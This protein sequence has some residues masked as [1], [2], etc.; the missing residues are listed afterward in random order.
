VRGVVF[1]GDKELELQT[2]ED[3]T[4]GPGE[5][6]LEMKAS[7]M[8]GTDLKFYR[9]PKPFQVRGAQF[10]AGHEPCGV[11]VA[12]GAG[13]T[14]QMAKAGDRVMVH[15][16]LGCTMCNH[17]RTGWSQ[18][19]AEVPV[20]AYGYSGHGGHAP[21]MVAP[22]QTLVKLP[23][24]LSYET[25]AAISCGT[26]TAFQA[27]TRMGVSGRDTIAIFGQGPVGASATQLA[28]AMGAEVIAVDINPKRANKAAEFGATHIVDASATDP[29]E[30]IR[31]LTRG[32]GVSKSLD[33]SGHS[34]ARAQ[35][36]Q[37]CSPWAT[38]AF[39]GEG[40][41]VTLDVSAWVL[42][43]Q[44]TVF[45]SWTFS[46]KGQRDCAEFIAARRVN[47][48]KIFTDRYALDQAAAAYAAFDKGEGG[49]GVFIF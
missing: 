32:R 1:T 22:V 21:Y 38:V 2:F 11:V 36:V 33:A 5:V 9:S 46:T 26:G 17:C 29:I 40:G 24:E 34:T 43:K 28:A 13:V 49:K 44:L 39:V 31:A 8:C 42:R 7:G 3:P 4:P 10:I 12:V 45:G 30:E 27:L 41:E 16:Y 19:C 37:S 15:H 20:V 14:P 23:D 47:C 35:A 6:V 18:M 25:G 48:D